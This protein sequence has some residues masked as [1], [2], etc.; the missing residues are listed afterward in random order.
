MITLKT[1]GV[2]IV[3]SKVQEEETTYKLNEY[4]NISVIK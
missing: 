2:N 4:I 1:V 3:K